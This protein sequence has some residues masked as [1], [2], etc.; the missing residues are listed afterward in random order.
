MLYRLLKSTVWQYCLHGLVALA[1]ESAIPAEVCAEFE[2]DRR[3]AVARWDWSVPER[4]LEQSRPDP[5]G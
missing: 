3:C 2:R 4:W 5:R 1:A